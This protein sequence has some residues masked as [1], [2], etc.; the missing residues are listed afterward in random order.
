MESLKN[1]AEANR[2]DGKHHQAT[3]EIHNEI[4]VLF[5][6]VVPGFDSIKT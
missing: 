1:F 5:E 6:F 3:Q 4:N 2:S